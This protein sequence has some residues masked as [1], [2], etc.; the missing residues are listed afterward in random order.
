MAYIVLMMRVWNNISACLKKITLFSCL[1]LGKLLCDIKR[2]WQAGKIKQL[3]HWPML[4]DLLL[5]PI[6]IDMFTLAIVAWIFVCFIASLMFSHFFPS[7]CSCHPSVQTDS[8]SKASE[9]CDC[10]EVH[11]KSKCEPAISL[12][13]AVSGGEAR[14]KHGLWAV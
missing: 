14:Q 9:K 1:L 3:H 13:G 12:I 10:R 7:K 11:L 8:W 4:R 5:A 2:F 6:Q